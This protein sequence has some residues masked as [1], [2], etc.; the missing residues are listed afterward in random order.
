MNKIRTKSNFKLANNLTLF[1]S[2]SNSLIYVFLPLYYFH[3]GINLGSIGAI[4]ALSLI[5]TNIAK[6][7]GG[8]LADNF[9]RKKTM[10]W[11]SGLMILTNLSLLFFTSELFFILR[12]II[13]GIAYAMFFPS[14]SS[15]VWDISQKTK[16]ATHAAIRSIYRYSGLIIAPVIGGLIIYL[17][18][19]KVLFIVSVL[20]GIYSIY[21]INSIT[22]FKHRD[23]LPTFGK[24]W[25]NYH[26]I[27]MTPGFTFLSF[28]HLAKV[29]FGLIWHTFILIYLI[30]IVGYDFWQ[31]GLVITG[32]Y[33]ILLPFQIPLGQLSDKFHS[34]W[35]I[36]PGF[37]LLGI[38]M[39]LF[40]VYTH[41][42]A[43]VLAGGGVAIGLLAIGRPIYVR[44][45]EMTPDRK[46][47]K[48]LALF[49]AI[50]WGLAAIM[51]FYVS[52]LAESRSIFFVINHGGSLAIGIGLIL[53]A[54]HRKISWK[55]GNYL[56]RH[57]MIRLYTPIDKFVDSFPMISKGF[58]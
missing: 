9:N 38:S 27:G 4:V 5:A 18:G 24:I 56:K 58:K 40:F 43:Y 46:H 13:F 7:Y 23:K 29:S 55:Y 48:A 21:L 11:S 45:A 20:I 10:I 8:S 26:K 37:I 16:L 51:L 53:I 31:A 47:G 57:H 15:Y 12:G 34:K 6:F 50:S 25:E 39:K 32:A 42:L 36:I 54:F 49:E 30:N 28:I 35:L 52:E 1:R 41:F 44:L 17:Y 3:L 19:F 22:E 14:Y 33:V 2:L